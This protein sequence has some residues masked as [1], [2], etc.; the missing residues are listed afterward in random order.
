VTPDYSVSSSTPT[1]AVAAGGTATYA[2]IVQSTGAFNGSVLLSVTGLPSGATASFSSNP[3]T[4]SSTNGSASTTLTVQ[5]AG[6]K[7][8]AMRIR[9][10]TLAAPA[11]LLV[12]LLPSRRL[13]RR[14]V[15]TFLLIIVI[16][17][18]LALMASMV[19]CGGGFAS[20][21]PYTLTITG[22]SGSDTYSTTVLLTVR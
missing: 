6:T 17:I 15:R 1:Q 9:S 11:I 13:R 18:S 19:G 22:T 8:A 12:M 7:L 16:L 5:T 3:I 2:V 20:S 10:W 14:H 21:Q 4:L